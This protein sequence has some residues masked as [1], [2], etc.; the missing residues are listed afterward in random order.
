MRL[1]LRLLSLSA[2]GLLGLAAP[3]R[4]QGV[5][6][7]PAPLP[8]Q[9]IYAPTSNV[10]VT[11]TTIVRTPI[12][13]TAFVQ[14][15][16]VVTYSTRPVYATTTTYVPTHSVSRRS[17]VCRPR[18]TFPTTD[19]VPRRADFLP[20]WL[21]RSAARSVRPGTDQGCLPAPPGGPLQLL[22]ADL[23]TIGPIR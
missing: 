4:S 10:V 11:P 19:F 7:L 5:V 8:G 9:T 1:H 13:P 23:G 2:L 15:P 18:R 16:P 22:I 12:G 3:A 21:R 17:D 20:R 6:G 14:A